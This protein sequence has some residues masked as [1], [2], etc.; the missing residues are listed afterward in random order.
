MSP[1]VVTHAYGDGIEINGLEALRQALQTERE[2]F[3][4]SI[5]VEHVASVGPYVAALV[6][7]RGTFSGE[8]GSQ[9]ATG[10]SFAERGVDIFRF[11]GGKVREWDNYRNLM[12][13]LRQLDLYP[14]PEK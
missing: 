13:L 1:D 12:D 9:K 10:K 3:K 5:D 7:V 11:E 8:L 4:G 14:P 2:G 6:Y